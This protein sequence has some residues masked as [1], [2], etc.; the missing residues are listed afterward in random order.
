[1]FFIISLRGIRAK[2]NMN[3]ELRSVCYIWCI[4]SLVSL[5]LNALPYSPVNDSYL[6]IFESVGCMALITVTIQIPLIQMKRY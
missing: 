3:M 5:T 1:M 4:Q 6:K 2:Y